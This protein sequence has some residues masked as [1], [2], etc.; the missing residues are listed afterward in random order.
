MELFGL[1]TP[2][3]V[4]GDDLVEIILKA[5][6]RRRLKLRDRDILVIATK[7]LSILEGR[8]VSLESC[9]PS[10]RALSLARKFSLEPG[11]TELV[12]RE[13]QKIY[14][15]VQRALLTL[16]NNILIAN[17][18]IDHSNVPA[19]NLVLWPRNCQR[20]AEMI[21]K[22]IFESTGKRVGV[23]V[24]DSRTTPL[25]MGTVGVALG[26]AGF[27]PV[28]DYRGK[29]DLFG[30]RMVIT[31]QAVADDL[32]SAAHLLMGETDE[33]VPVVLVRDAPVEFS[34][35]NDPESIMI[36]PKQCMF[37]KTLKATDPAC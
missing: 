21:R 4:A 29:K 13:S 19:G 1:Q 8:V 23:A 7:V 5:L 9:T 2:V 11:C 16:K 30:N 15:G 37:M 32:V 25:R 35:R 26:I 20:S 31:R 22:R 18:G 36:S 14:G 3:M 34:E 28:K 6:K 27:R 24:V 10:K 33:R 12:I 17:A